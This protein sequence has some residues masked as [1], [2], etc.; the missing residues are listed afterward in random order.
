MIFKGVTQKRLT[1]VDLATK[2]D[3]VIASSDALR[4]PNLT[5][6]TKTGNNFCNALRVCGRSAGMGQQK[7]HSSGQHAGSAQRGPLAQ[8]RL[9]RQPCLWPCMAQKAV[10]QASLTCHQASS[11]V[12]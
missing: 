5:A 11:Q 12:M 2:Y 1:A 10:L 3:V 6:K 9:Q 7:A 4:P 8:H